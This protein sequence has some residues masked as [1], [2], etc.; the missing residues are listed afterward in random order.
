[1]GHFF[2]NVVFHAEISPEM[3]H[4]LLKHAEQMTYRQFCLLKIAQF[5]NDRSRLRQEDY[6]GDRTFPLELQQVLYE[7]YDL[8]NRG[9]INF[10]GAAALGVTDVKPRAMKVQGMGLTLA[11]LLGVIFIPEEDLSPIVDQLR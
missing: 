2:S 9:F 1:M 6:R 11:I 4:H 7:I 10:G 8:Y 3:A 5:D